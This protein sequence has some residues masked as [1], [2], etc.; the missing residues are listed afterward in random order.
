[1]TTPV[2]PGAG[3]HPTQ[4]IPAATTAT[5]VHDKADTQ[6]TRLR[7]AVRGVLT[8]GIAVSVAANVL[9]A[10]PNPIS[11]VIAAWPPLAL[12][13]AVEIVARVP[14]HRSLWARVRVS[15]AGVIALIAAYVSYWHMAGV[16]VRY[17]ESS[18]VAYLLPF[19]VDGL[20]V[21]ASISLFE[22]NNHQHKTGTAA[23]I[24]AVS[25]TGSPIAAT[26]QP[27]AIATPQP[28]RAAV[29]DP[30]EQPYADTKILPLP[31]GGVGAWR[32]SP[33]SPRGSHH[34]DSGDHRHRWP[35]EPAPRPDRQAATP[36]DAAQTLDR[37]SLPHPPQAAVSPPDDA[38]SAAS[39]TRQDPN[40]GPAEN[41]EKTRKPERATRRNRPS[42]GGAARLDRK[43]TR[44]ASA[45]SPQAIREWAVENGYEIGERGPLP[46]PVV[47]AFH[48]RR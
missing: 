40:G 11:Q 20:I 4:A 47:A 6:Q 38:V 19:S 37:A 39:G 17:G 41:A 34:D 33:V 31:V 45:A 7:W 27:E 28:Q 36:T 2:S 15:M 13:V 44:S 23:A 43:D 12:A 18:D 1:M 35:V 8:L 21:V 42:G 25:A 5:A 16:I 48:A 14:V 30:A 26:R 9:H 22:L 29:V 46:E 10:D 24:S 32:S 3:P